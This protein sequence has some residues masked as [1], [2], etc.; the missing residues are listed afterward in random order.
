[1]FQPAQCRCMHFLRSKRTLKG[2]RPAGYDST[3]WDSQV[4]SR[5]D[6][7]LVSLTWGSSLAS[8]PRIRRCSADRSRSI[9]NRYAKPIRTDTHA[10]RFL[11][12]G[13][14]LETRYRYAT[15]PNKG[16]CVRIGRKPAQREKGLGLP[17]IRKPNALRGSTRYVPAGGVRS[18]SPQAFQPS[19]RTRTPPTPMPHSVAVR[20]QPR[21]ET[22]MHN[23]RSGNQAAVLWHPIAKLASRT[24]LGLLLGR[25]LTLAPE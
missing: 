13:M 23:S 25:D 19:P 2:T 14:F 8:M 15:P 12:I 6:A 20:P 3:A 9:W 10:Y 1:M 17:P 22:R 5:Q 11:L 7:E 18:Q 24:A 4:G 16:E 21:C